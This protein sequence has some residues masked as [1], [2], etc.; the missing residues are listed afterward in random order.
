MPWAHTDND[1]EHDAAASV[2]PHTAESLPLIN[3]N[4]IRLI[5]L[6]A[7]GHA[8]DSFRSGDRMV[9][10]QRRAWEKRMRAFRP[11]GAE[12]RM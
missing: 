7:L 9:V 6:T 4:D 8:S 2:M 1:L 10:G 11:L 5:E 3:A 12:Q